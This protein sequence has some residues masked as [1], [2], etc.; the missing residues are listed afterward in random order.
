MKFIA[1]L[2][3]GKSGG[4]D[5]DDEKKPPA[6]GGLMGRGGPPPPT[7]EQSQEATKR[8][9][10]ENMKSRMSLQR[11]V[12]QK[13]TQIKALSRAGRTA[14][15]KRLIPGLK[16]SEAR[17]E[18]KEAQIETLRSQLD[19]ASDV[20]AAKATADAI[21]ATTEA[22]RAQM[23][24]L[25]PDEID[26][27]MVGAGR[28]QSDMEE[29]NAALGMTS[30]GIDSQLAEEEADAYLEELMA[31]DRPLQQ[32]PVYMPSVP[33][34]VPVPQPSAPPMSNRQQA[35]MQEHGH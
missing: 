28:M 35:P 20:T 16:R 18:Q 32:E 33:D 9:I 2:I 5:D 4:D 23:G 19:L 11:E 3:S 24:T 17:L 6:S 22:T 34:R 21:K 27:I 30:G 26:G 29:I 1:S 8:A 13:K 12:N 7:I 10:A 25:D 15:A 14:E 31:E